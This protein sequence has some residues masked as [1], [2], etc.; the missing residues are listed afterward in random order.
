MGTILNLTNTPLK[1]IT[2]VKQLAELKQQWHDLERDNAND[3]T[4][5]QSYDWI[6]TWCD[7]YLS[8]DPQIEINIFVGLE[9][10]KLVFVLPLMKTRQH[11]LAILKWLT[12]PVGQYGDILCAT[13]HSVSDWMDKALDMIKRENGADLIRLRHVRETSNI[14]NFA[15]QKFV[16]AK[17]YE[18]APFLDLTAFKTDAD[19]TERYTSTQRKRRKKI[20]KKL[21]DE[22]GKVEFRILTESTESDQ[23][24]NN[25]SAE[26]DLWLD[27]RGRVNNVMA[28]QRHL[29]FLIN[30]SRLN[31][32]G[33]QVVTSQLSAGGKPI[34]WEIGFRHFGK[35]FA[36]MT[37]HV[38][39]LTDYS[40]GRIHMDL[41]QRAALSAGQ[42]IFDLMVPNDAHKESWCSG[43]INVNDYFFAISLKGKI[44]GYGFLKTIRPLMRAAYYATPSWLL[45][46]LR[47]IKRH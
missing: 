1:R 21:E 46:P 34:S 17:F 12:D 42:T 45:R 15:K 25:A 9:N 13:G 20:A 6:K 41:S 26:K 14:E 31:S 43:K 11:G 22:I 19:Y 38:N 10:A 4:V 40:P 32:A 3:S 16:D 27:E 37:S 35:H 7:V 28:S 44:Y 24:I 2:T 47:A 36:Y 5:F 39:A 8:A 29:Q 23:A 33:L 30:L 18:Q